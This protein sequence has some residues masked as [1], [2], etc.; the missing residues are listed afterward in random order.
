MFKCVLEQN[1]LTVESL[2]RNVLSKN[3]M[4]VYIMT[5]RIGTVYISE[6]FFKKVRR[7]R[8]QE[9]EKN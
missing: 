4:Y 6:P 2:W 1:I 8:D 5:Q 3:C 7:F 9:R